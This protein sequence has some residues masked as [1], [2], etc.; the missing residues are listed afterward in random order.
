MLPVNYVTP[1]RLVHDCLQLEYL[2]ANRKICP[3]FSKDLLNARKI[4]EDS[5]EIEFSN[6]SR[7]EPGLAIELSSNDLALLHRI[8][9]KV[10]HLETCE[11]LD[12]VLNTA[13]DWMGIEGE[14][15]NSP[16]DMRHVV[17]DNFLNQDALNRIQSFLNDSWI[18][19]NDAQKGFSYL[20]AYRHNGLA[21]PAIDAL[22]KELQLSLPHVLSDIALTQVWAY[23][24]ILGSKA[25]GVHADFARINVNLWLTPDCWNKNS[26][27]GGLRLF[28][29]SRSESATFDEYNGNDAA[30]ASSIRGARELRIPYRCNRA[31]IFDSSLFHGSERSTFAPTYSGLR[32]NLTMLFG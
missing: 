28:S 12:G 32:T 22:A 27:A 21:C 1:A 25:V 6:W 18:W 15:R 5:F 4:F 16:L 23:R 24:N 30:I 13:L 9:R 3:S 19:F 11:S 7:C 20:G 10:V 14:F 8:H 26:D 31:V 17:I 2:L 29:T